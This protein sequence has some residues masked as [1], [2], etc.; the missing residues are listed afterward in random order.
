MLKLFKSLNIVFK[1]KFQFKTKFNEVNSQM[2]FS[3]EISKQW[4]ERKLHEIE[5]LTTEL[6]AKHGKELMKRKIDFRKWKLNLLFQQ[7]SWFRAQ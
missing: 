2:N 4:L 3:F 5:N 6:E 7:V 1:Y